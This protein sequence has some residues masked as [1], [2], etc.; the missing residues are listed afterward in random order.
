[1]ATTT[2]KY[3]LI[4]ERLSH[5]IK[6]GDY[7]LH[8]VPAERELASQVG[9]SYM[10][11]RKA[12]QVLLDRGLL[13]RL[14]NGRL[15]VRSRDDVNA[16]TKHV[17]LLAPAWET[18]DAIL[19][20]IA[21]SQLRSRLHF[22]SRMVHYGHW[23]D[24]VIANT[25][26]QFD[27]T[28][29]L[30]PEPPVDS[31]AA[32]LAKLGRPLV[33]LNRDWSDLGVRSVQMLPPRM[34]QKLLDHLAT[35]GH[36]RVDCFNV[37]PCGLTM[38]EW[39]GQWEVW[40]AAHGISGELINEPVQPYTETL[41][42]AYNVIANRIRQGRFDSKALF[43][44]TET[45]AIG[46]VRAMLDHGIRP[47]HDVAVC[48]IGSQRC[49]YLPLTITTLEQPNRMPYLAACMEWLLAPK[50]GHWQGPLLIQPQDLA[51]VVRESTVPDVI[52]SHAPQRMRRIGES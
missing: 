34:I 20:N 52:K 5:R 31:F 44:L 35:L 48:T 25:I 41:V 10:T 22:A 9:V 13:T 43:C 40:R 51:V 23:D 11:V 8:G 14:P 21:L 30:P 24:P 18:N 32:D 36:R 16:A 46:A 4:A 47:G 17:A 33:V 2:R 12:V 49:E 15:A 38:R 7:H 26:Q 45:A 27:A 50:A 1:M 39:I 3:G 37:Q 28:L 6:N 42:A 19:W 29:L